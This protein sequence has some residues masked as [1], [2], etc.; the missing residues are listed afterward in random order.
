M[1]REPECRVTVEVD[2]GSPGSNV[3]ATPWP[4]TVVHCAADG[5]EIDLIATVPSTA[6]R[7]GLPGEPGS[8]VSAPPWSSTA[9]HWFVDGQAMS[10]S[11]P[12]VVIVVFVCDAGDCGSKTAT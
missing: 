8:N 10:V 11:V 12:T 9:V 1:R 7:A 4:S 5:Q 2:A 6:W 3:T